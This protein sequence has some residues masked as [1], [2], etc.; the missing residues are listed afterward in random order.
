MVTLVNEERSYL[1]QASCWDRNRAS[2]GTR[3]ANVTCD[4]IR[5]RITTGRWISKTRVPQKHTGTS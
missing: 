5:N 4:Y 1:R 2:G 3:G